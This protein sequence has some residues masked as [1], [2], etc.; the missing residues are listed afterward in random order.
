L[1]EWWPLLSA[2]EEY[3]EEAVFYQNTLTEA[4]NIE[5]RTLLELGSGGGN[6]AS[7]L[8]K[9]FQLTLVD[10]SPEM[11]E[12]S[13]QLN[14]G[15]EHLTGDMRSVRLNR[16]FDAV[17]VHDAVSY[18]TSI[19]DLRATLETAFLH[20]RC[21][22]AV[23]LAPDVT[24]ETFTPYTSHGGHDGESRSLRYLEWVWDPDPDDKT[25]QL[26]MVYTLR[27]KGKEPRVESETHL[28]GLFQQDEWLMLMKEAGFVPK[29]VSF[30]PGCGDNVG[31]C[32]FAGVKPAG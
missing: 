12:V 23:L 29:A 15:C 10:L 19:G 26:F 30:D 18:I 8:K 5:I 13:R 1:A 22:G 28:L 4:S 32:V 24:T 27:E 14:P 16:E 20:C 6:N 21:G 11:I 9:R 2:P 7:Y 3:A 17:F 25:Y 31:T